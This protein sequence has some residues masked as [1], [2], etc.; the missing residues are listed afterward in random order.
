MCKLF[1]HNPEARCISSQ[2]L[3]K[4]S[5][6]LSSAEARFWRGFQPE[7]YKHYACYLAFAIPVSKTF[8]VSP[9][10][11]RSLRSARVNHRGADAAPAAST[12]PEIISQR[13]SI[14]T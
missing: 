5:L 7:T 2:W 10:K 11:E 13:K 3:E 8:R 14:R 9:G 12:F 1:A 6:S 4:R